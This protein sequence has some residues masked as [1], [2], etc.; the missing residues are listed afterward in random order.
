MQTWFTADTHFG[1]GNIITYCDRPFDDVDSMRA[2]LVR[3]WN[4]RVSADD[5]IF[6]LG[7][8]AL[9]RIEQTLTVLE[10]LNGAKHLVVGNHDRPFD[11]DPRRR[12]EW[13]ARYLAAG[14]RSV[15]NGTVGYSLGGR[16][17]VLIGH[18]P[19]SGDSHGEDRYAEQRPFD[20]GLP[21][22]HG[23][24]HTGWRLQGR[25]LNVGVDAC[26]YAPISEDD[27]IAT[28]TE[29]GVLGSS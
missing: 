20:T 6:V 7:D 21:I 28:L 8:F 19:Y 13:T 10:E 1:H 14:F 17:P 12:A 22:V 25:Q 5:Q 26:D 18:F 16:H 4:E 24:V 3:R 9:G 11:P 27:V 2:E 23:H 29:A 15:T